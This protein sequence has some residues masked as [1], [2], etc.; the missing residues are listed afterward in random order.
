MTTGKLLAVKLYNTF[1]EPVDGDD[2]LSLA[3]TGGRGMSFTVRGQRYYTL[4]DGAY[5]N[6]PYGWLVVGGDEFRRLYT[7]YV[8]TGEAEVVLAGIQNNYLYAILTSSEETEN[9]Y[10]LGNGP[11]FTVSIDKLFDT[12]RH[13]ILTDD[14]VE[15]ELVSILTD[16]GILAQA[17]DSGYAFQNYLDRTISGPVP[18][19]SEPKKENNTMNLNLSNTLLKNIHCG[20]AGPGFGI[21]LFDGAI[22]YKGHSFN[23]KSLVET[24]GFELDAG[25]FLFIMPTTSIKKG[26]I[27]VFNSGAAYYDGESFISLTTGLKAEYVPVSCFGMTFYSVVRNMLGNIANTNG[28]G[29]NNMANLLPLMLLDKGGDSD[30]IMKLMLLMNGGFN[31]NFAN[32]TAAAPVEPTK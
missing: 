3:K 24:A 8:E 20:K 30:N 16:A 15:T 7:N 23:G 26:D 22:T 17:E 13:A 2:V 5:F 31:F 4:T 19:T 25:D 21:S 9:D 11:V 6:S 32:P 12:L 1:T 28:N 27:V 29:G 14:N 10:Q 18:I